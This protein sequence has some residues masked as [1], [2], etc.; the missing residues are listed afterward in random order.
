MKAEV[1]CYSRTL[2]TRVSQGPTGPL[3]ALLKRWSQ[4]GGDDGVG[5]V[6]KL[7]K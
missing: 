2:L 3:A 5:H 7:R 6:G 1:A 4:D